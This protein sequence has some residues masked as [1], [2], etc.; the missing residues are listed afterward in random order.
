VDKNIIKGLCWWFISPDFNVFYFFGLNLIRSN[1][2]HSIYRCYDRSLL[3][4]RVKILNVT[5]TLAHTI[6]KKKKKKIDDRGIIVNYYL[7]FLTISFI[8]FFVYREIVRKSRYSL[9][10][11]KKNAVFK[12]FLEQFWWKSLVSKA[13]RKWVNN[14]DAFVDFSA[15]F[16][17]FNGFFGD[18][19]NDLLEICTDSVWYRLWLNQ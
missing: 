2:I 6:K 18:K 16:C 7:D 19:E 14:E 12:W 4:K 9:K 8:D 17:N 13:A 3:H 1:P 11:K 15:Q 10:K 5:L